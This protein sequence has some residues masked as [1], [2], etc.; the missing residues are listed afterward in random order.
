MNKKVILGILISVLLIYLSVRGIHLDDV[1]SSFKKIHFRFVVYFTVFVVLM[2]FLRSYRWGVILEP[3][4]KID[5]F[6]LFSVTSVG[7]MAIAALPARLGELARPYLISQKSSIKMSSALGTILIERILDSFTVLTIALFILIRIELPRWMM[8]SSFF[9]LLLVT[10][11]FGFVLFLLFFRDRSLK[12]INMILN[13]LPGKF[14][15][16][17]D[18]L[19]HSFIDGFQVITNIRILLYLFFLSALIWLVDV[20]AIHMLILAFGFPL[21]L[22]ASF[23]VMI[24]LIV[25]IALPAGPGYIGNWHYACI[26]AL[27]IFGLEKSEALSFA[28]VYHFLSMIIVLALGIAFLPMNRFSLTDIKRQINNPPQN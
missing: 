19:L 21:Q 24:I 25:G 8:N 14:A 1:I 3:L 17:I 4:E 2:Q 26:L 16:R 20:A 13:K 10:I 27:G 23:V 28:V 12:Y 7:F 22:I 5:P 6:F 9:F 11:M 18:H 15:N